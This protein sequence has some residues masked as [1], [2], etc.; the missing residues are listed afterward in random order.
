MNIDHPCNNKPVRIQTYLRL[1]QSSMHPITILL[2]PL[3]MLGDEQG[4]L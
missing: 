1:I 4:L 2:D 3:E